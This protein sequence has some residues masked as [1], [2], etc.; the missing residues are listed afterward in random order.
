MFSIRSIVLTKV[1]IINKCNI[2]FCF[3]GYKYQHKKQGH[4]AFKF[5]KIVQRFA[6]RFALRKCVEEHLTVSPSPSK[7]RGE[8]IDTC[9]LIS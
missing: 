9:K 4:N 2:Y 1:L 8:K 6:Q 7:R 5:N 3:V